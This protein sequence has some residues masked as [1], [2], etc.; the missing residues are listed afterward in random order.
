[1]PTMAKHGRTTIGEGR[2][3]RLVDDGGW[4]FV[5]RKRTTGIAVIVAVTDDRE[6][7]LVEQFRR[8]V[9]GNVVELP[10]GLAGDVAGSEGEALVEAARREL[11]EETGYD[12]RQMEVLTEGPPSAGL[13]SEV[14][15]FLRATGLRRIGGGGGDESEEITVHRI[16]LRT[17]R[18]WLDRK[19]A[20]GAM[21]DP[22]LWAGLYFAVKR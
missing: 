3:L 6:I 7:L 20:E 15:T 22:K 1:M 4:E 16:P 9:G 13:S 11:I 2:W 8:P 21:I 18:R 5:E 12:A 17:L 10:A 19:V 14:V